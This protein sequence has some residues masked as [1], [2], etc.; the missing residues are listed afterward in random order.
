MRLESFILRSCETSIIMEYLYAA[1]LLHKLKQ[2]ITEEN[3]KNV[4][5]A[6]G[7]TPDE[8]RIKALVAAIGEVNIDEALKNASMPVQQVQM[9][10]SAAPSASA[11]PT[12]KEEKKE[13]KKEE[14]ALEGL[15][16]LFG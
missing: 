2:D 12:E 11:I 3:V 13:E 9:S 8:I 7:A 1:L 15:S 5:K 10:A 4:V 6:T 16:A 14:E